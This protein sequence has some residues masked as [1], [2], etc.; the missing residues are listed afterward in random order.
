MIDPE[1]C[2]YLH[3]P[4]LDH[5]VVPDPTNDILN[6]KDYNLY[7]QDEDLKSKVHLILSATFPNLQKPDNITT[8]LAQ[9]E[10]D[11]PQDFQWAG[12]INVIKHA[13]VGNGFF[14]KVTSPRITK[15]FIESGRLGPFFESMEDKGW[16]VTIHCDCGKYKKNVAFLMSIL[17]NLICL[18][19][20]TYT[21]DL[22]FQ[23]VTIT[24]PYPQEHST[25]TL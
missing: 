23:V 6:A 3:C 24:M 17:I 7:K 15:R 11:F 18:S 5:K 14:D 8:I 20:I 4:T 13:L 25:I 22:S 21:N 19:Y 10:N 9:L 1:C 12:E 16:P 2:Y